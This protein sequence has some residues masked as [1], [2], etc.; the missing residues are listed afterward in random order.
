[1]TTSGRVQMVTSRL[2]P[3]KFFSSQIRF[4]DVGLAK[5]SISPAG[6][7]RRQ[8]EGSVDAIPDPGGLAR[9]TRS[10]ST[11]QSRDVMRRPSAAPSIASFKD[12][13]KDGMKAAGQTFWSKSTQPRPDSFSDVRAHSRGPVPGRVALRQ[14]NHVVTECLIRARRASNARTDI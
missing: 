7:A 5:M 11:E 10:A 8:D 12:G 14:S 3:F 6:S 9:A 13:M 2:D 4:W 1:L